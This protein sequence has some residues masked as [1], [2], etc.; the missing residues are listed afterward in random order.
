M[1][2]HNFI[3]VPNS[4]FTGVGIGLL[5]ILGVWDLAWKAYGMWRAAR[6]NQV[7]WFV[8]ILIFN[9]IGILPILYIYVFSKKEPAQPTSTQQ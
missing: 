8:A 3:N 7:W 6:N 2:Y 9:T 5:A 1:D 4:T